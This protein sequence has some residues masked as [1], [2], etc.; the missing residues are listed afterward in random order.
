MPASL[1]SQTLRDL[2]ETTTDIALLML[3]T[4]THPSFAPQRFV[5]NNE[6]IDSRGNRYLPLW[7]QL[8]LPD[9]TRERPTEVTLRID[10]VALDLIPELRRLTTA[11]TLL[12]E[13]VSTRNLDYVELEVADLKMRDLKWDAQNILFECS[14]EDIL[15][16]R[17]PAHSYAPLRYPGIFPG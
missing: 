3:L 16:E 11:P 17:F 7:F 12:I 9:D 14:W 2:F 13:V 1:T 10:G 6:P 5:N 4:V 15:N 8:T